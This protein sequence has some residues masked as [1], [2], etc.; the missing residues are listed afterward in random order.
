MAPSQ[1]IQVVKSIL[2]REFFKLYPEIKRKY[3]WAGKLW[4]QTYLVETIGNTNEETIR[5]YVQNQLVELD[6]KEQY[7]KQLGLF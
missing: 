7:A 6:L 3:F 4:I 1:I 2:A 5:K